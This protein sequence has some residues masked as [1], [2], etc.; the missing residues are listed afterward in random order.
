MEKTPAV[1]VHS[2][3]NIRLSAA[4]FTVSSLTESVMVSRLDEVMDFVNS[5]R[6]EYGNAYG[7]KPEPREYFLNGLNR[8]WEFSYLIEEISSKKI[9]FVGLCSVYD[10]LLHLHCAYAA[11]GQRRIGLGRFF[12]LKVCQ[13]GIDKGFSEIEGFW[14]KHN[15]G[16]LILFLR[17]GYQIEDLRKAGTQ[18]LLSANLAA[19][20]ERTIQM[21]L[22][23]VD[24]NTPQR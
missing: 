16:S 12:N 11:R 10:N 19:S 13:V 18:L 20:R 23:D 17:M 5:I 9:S 3:V 24:A 7:W 21:I 6:G 2:L 8:K 1:D 14:P 4:G 15:S 22:S